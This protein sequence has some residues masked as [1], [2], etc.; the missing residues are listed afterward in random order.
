[1]NSE[2][3]STRIVLPTVY[4]VCLRQFTIVFELEVVYHTGNVLLCDRRFET[5]STIIISVVKYERSS[6]NTFLQ[7]VLG[8]F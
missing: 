2:V 7:D 5:V 6:K 4:A 1:M 3:T 8:I